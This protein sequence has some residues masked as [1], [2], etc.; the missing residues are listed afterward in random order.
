MQAR[1][2]HYEAVLQSLQSAAKSDLLGTGSW[3]ARL[4]GLTA[5]L[6]ALT[7]LDQRDAAL[8]LAQ[9][10]SHNLTYSQ[11]DLLRITTPLLSAATIDIADKL[12]EG[13]LM[14]PDVKTD[15][16]VHLIWRSALVR[17]GQRRIERMTDAL[18]LVTSKASLSSNE[19]LRD[20]FLSQLLTR[21]LRSSKDAGLAGVAAERL[22]DRD[23]QTLALVRQAQ[24][25]PDDRIASDIYWK[26]FTEQ[27]LPD[28]EL[29]RAGWRHVATELPE[30]AVTTF[31][32]R[33]RQ[34]R[35]LRVTEQ[36]RFVSAFKLLKLSSDAARV[37]SQ[38]KHESAPAPE[39]STFPA[40]QTGSGF[41]SVTE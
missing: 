41:F 17:T 23:L 24:L 28:T 31:E 20:S 39:A 16:E 6:I 25:D 36:R 1:R 15:V 21:E 33:L 34:G 22:K 4:D 27:R 26:L 32:H 29:E 7:G 38:S 35:P 37:E 18:N 19:S 2:H 13:L 14:R 5:E 8:D 9:R 12:I 11:Q 30:R 10:V 3:T 40:P